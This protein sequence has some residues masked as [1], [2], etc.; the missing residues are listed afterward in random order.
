MIKNLKNIY[1]KIPN[2]LFW[3]IFFVV[4]LSL[5]LTLKGFYY[6][7]YKNGTSW[8][9]GAMGMYSSMDYPGTRYAHILYKN[10]E[11]EVE[12]MVGMNELSFLVFKEYEAFISLPTNKNAFRL[13]KAL[14]KKDIL[15]NQKDGKFELIVFKLLYDKNTKII[16]SKIVMNFVL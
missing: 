13:K 3:G 11:G 10:A 7:Y 14:I 9:F 8:N 4:S 1:L 5:I 16:S 6:Y 2:G 15:S 12:R